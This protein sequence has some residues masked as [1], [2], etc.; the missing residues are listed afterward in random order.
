[1]FHPVFG[2]TKLLEYCTK[3]LVEHYLNWLQNDLK[4]DQYIESL[5]KKNKIAQLIKLNLK[6]ST[7]E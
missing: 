5:M 2:A 6:D 1:M 7:I 3:N 4:D